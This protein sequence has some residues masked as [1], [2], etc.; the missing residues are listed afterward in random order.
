M[1]LNILQTKLNIP[2]LRPLIV[3]RRRLLETLDQGLSQ[4]L[5]LTLISAPAGSGKTTLLA[6]WLETLSQP[7]AWISLDTTDND[8]IQ[9]ITYLITSLQNVKP[10]VGDSILQTIGSGMDSGNINSGRVETILQPLIND[11]IQIDHPLILVLDDYH[12]IENPTIHSA[13]NFLINN[14]PPNAY[15]V[16]STRSD[17]SLHLANL[18]ARGQIVEI[19]ATDLR[20]TLPESTTFLNDTMKLKLTSDEVA[21][22]E[23]RTEGWIAG[24]Q[25]AATSLQSQTNIPEFI[26]NFSGSNRFILDYLLEEVLRFESEERYSFLLTTSILNRITGTLCDALTEHSNGQA[27]LEQLENLRHEV[28]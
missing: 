10:A 16:I 9:F 22:L 11:L 5:R 19:R 15:V 7:A 8:P 12:V 1:N 2:P 18:R 14:L 27:M 20:F 24:L 26:E 21:S 6:H 25:L 13:I 28:K 23:K 3:Q 17:P 4:H